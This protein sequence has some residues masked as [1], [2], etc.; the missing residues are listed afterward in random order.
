MRETILNQNH[1]ED[2]DQDSSCGYLAE[3][4]TV[5]FTVCFQSVADFYGLYDIPEEKEI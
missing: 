4:N 3:H 5:S 1:N 2:N